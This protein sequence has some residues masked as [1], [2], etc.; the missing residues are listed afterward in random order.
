MDG[1]EIGVRYKFEC[2]R[3][4]GSVAW[5]EEVT[6]LV[7][8]VGRQYVLNSAFN[9]GTAY[10][11]WYI[12]LFAT[13]YTPLDDDTLAKLLAA[14]PEF[15]S[16]DESQRVAF[17]ADALGSGSTLIN[18]G[19]LAV[20]TASAGATLY[21]AFMTNQPTKSNTTGVLVSAAKFSTARAIL[22]DEIIRVTAGLVLASA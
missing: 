21:G 15:T 1:M 10:S 18:S 19:S 6:N 5:I 17:T 4:D 8:L 14:A 9:G 16:Y 20:F 3:P 13:N 12:G 22:T 7:P 2:I 11:A